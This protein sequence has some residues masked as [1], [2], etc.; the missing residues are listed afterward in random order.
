M[1]DWKI[2]AKKLGVNLAIAAL[3][4]IIAFL[5]ADVRYA[6]LIPVVQAILNILKHNE[7]FNK[8]LQES[9]KKYL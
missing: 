8:S 4:T 6:F 1:I 5:Q 9:L 2:W 3:C 7:F